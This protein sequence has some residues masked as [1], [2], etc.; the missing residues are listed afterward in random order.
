MVAAHLYYKSK[1]KI[2]VIFCKN[3][4]WHCSVNSLASLSLFFFI[5]RNTDRPDASAV[6]LHDF[7]RFLLH[8]QQVGRL[9]KFSVLFL[10]IVSQNSMLIKNKCD[11]SQNMID[12]SCDTI[13]WKDFSLFVAAEVHKNYYFSS[14]QRLWRCTRGRESEQNK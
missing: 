14:I 3:I 6:H 5:L 9:Q 8:E 7:Q 13:P 11:V 12:V 1:I 4:W 2:R 10:E